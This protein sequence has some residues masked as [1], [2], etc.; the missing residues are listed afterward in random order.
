[1][2]R[3]NGYL[4]EHNKKF[5]EVAKN[6]ITNAVN[7]KGTKHYKVIESRDFFQLLSDLK[8]KKSNT[9]CRKL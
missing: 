6:K 7:N 3:I 4:K 5:M 8:L 2:N 1:M 9:V